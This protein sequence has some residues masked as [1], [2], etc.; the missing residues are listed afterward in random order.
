MYAKIHYEPPK[1]G[2][3]APPLLPLNPPLMVSHTHSSG[4]IFVGMLEDL[5]EEWL[6]AG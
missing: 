3:F 4:S 6:I 5:L 1:E 2:A